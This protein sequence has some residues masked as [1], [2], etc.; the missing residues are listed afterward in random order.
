MSEL[1]Q[2]YNELQACLRSLGKVAVAFSGG[3]DSTFLLKTAADT[4][5]HSAIAVTA[6]S[7]AFP[8]RELNETV[9]FTGENGIRHIIFDSEELDIEDFRQNPPNR[10]YI[11]KKHIFTK[12]VEISRQNGIP[13]VAEGSNIDDDL[14]YRPGHKAIAELGIKSP[15]RHEKLT[16]N[17]MI[18]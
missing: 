15:L 12:I 11:C 5:C 16:K 1:N 18:E 4:L 8:E 7:A 17:D 3:V 2:Q 6:R 9:R 13:H 10:C 14:D